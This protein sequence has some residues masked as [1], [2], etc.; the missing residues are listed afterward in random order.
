MSSL[1]IKVHMHIV[2][3]QKT[4]ESIKE[5]EISHKSI[6]QESVLTLWHASWNLFPLR[7]HFKYLKNMYQ[8]LIP[9]FAKHSLWKERPEFTL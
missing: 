1:F 2:Q 4:D 3:I 6:T 7:C 9:S 8:W 5:K